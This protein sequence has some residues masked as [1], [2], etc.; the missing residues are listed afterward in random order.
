M[1]C[2]L[3]SSMMSIPSDD[4]ARQFVLFGQAIFVAGSTRQDLRRE[5]ADLDA[6]FRTPGQCTPSVL[7]GRMEAVAALAKRFPLEHWGNDR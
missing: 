1:A 5:V 2:Y 3:S 6:G 4:T 7:T